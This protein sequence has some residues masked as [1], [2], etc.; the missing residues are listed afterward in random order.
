V[1]PEGWAGEYL[2]DVGV[3]RKRFLGN[4]GLFGRTFFAVYAVVKNNSRRLKVPTIIYT[5]NSILQTEKLLITI[6]HDD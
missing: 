4:A 1:I 2:S 5:F 6:I 3:R